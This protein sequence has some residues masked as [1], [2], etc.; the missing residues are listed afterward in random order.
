M[1]TITIRPFFTAKLLLFG[2]AALT[3]LSSCDVGIRGNGHITTENRPISDFTTIEAHGAFDIEWSPGAPALAITTDEN[4]QRHVNASVRSHKLL[5]ETRDRLRTTR[6]LR[7]RLTSSA[8][9]GAA[10]HGA[11]ILRAANI[12]ARDFYLDGTGATTTT[13]SGTVNALTASM[14]G[15]SKLDADQLR[16]Q[17]AELVITGAGKAEVMATERLRVAISGAGKVLYAGD[18]KTVEK[19]VTGAGTIRRK[20]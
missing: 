20:D 1:N 18:P 7:V 5:L 17:N 6:K 13:L 14:S 19:R 2:V 15:A 12:T 9:S 10:L 3:L 4:L 16:A 8:L 11:V